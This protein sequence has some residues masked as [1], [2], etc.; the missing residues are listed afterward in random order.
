LKIIIEK[1]FLI[2]RRINF[3]SSLLCL[4]EKKINS[5]SKLFSG[6]TVKQLIDQ[7]IILEIKRLLVNTNL[8]DKKV[9]FKTGFDDI[10]S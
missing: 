8:S 5:I 1:N 10:K 4:S 2:H 3:Y 9:A 7:R 6:K